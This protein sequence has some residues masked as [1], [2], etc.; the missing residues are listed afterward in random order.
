MWT[1]VGHAYKKGIGLLSRTVYCYSLAGVATQ[2][3]PEIGLPE[4]RV[5]VW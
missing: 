2:M 4:G 1:A 5:D 3:S